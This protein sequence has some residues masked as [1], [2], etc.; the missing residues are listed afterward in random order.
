MSQGPRLPLHQAHNLATRI[1]A[2]LEQYCQRIIIVGSIR[3]QRPNVGD[4]EL[5]VIPKFMPSLLP[6]VPGESLLDMALTTW[7]KSGRLIQANRGE[8]FKQ[9]FI[10]HLHGQG[11]NFKLEIN[12]SSP[13]RWAVEVAIKTGSTAFSKQLVTKRSKG[14]LLPSDCRITEGWQIW[15]GQDML[16]F[17]EEREFIEFCCNRWVQPE[18]RGEVWANQFNGEQG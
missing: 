4:I 8:T 13:E 16:R 12:V 3:R 9:F 14:G 15:R 6:D 17:T 7:L 5:V 11:L 1:A 2:E 10:P 18:A